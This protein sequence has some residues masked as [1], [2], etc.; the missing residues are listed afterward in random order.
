MQN[1]TPEG[2]QAIRDLSNRYR[3]S[4]EAVKSMFQ[5]VINGGGTMAQFNHPE[6]GGG[7]QWMQGGMTMIGDMFNQSLKFTVEG[8]CCELSNLLSN[9]SMQYTSNQSQSQNGGSQQQQGYGNVTG[10]MSVN[11][12]VSLFVQNSSQNWWPDVLGQANS[13]GGQNNV[14]YAYF[15]NKRRVA[16]EINNQVTVYDTLDH[17]IGGFSQQQGV[18]GSITL[19][20]Q[21][22]TV[23]IAELPI[24]TFDLDKTN[25]NQDVM[26]SEQVQ[27]DQ[28][29][30]PQPNNNYISN[31]K[32]LVNKTSEKMDIIATI[33]R[34][35]ELMGKGFITAEEFATKKTELLAKL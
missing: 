6:F 18:G 30:I 5:A 1:L 2:I 28:N 15:E 12:P 21:Y 26:K 3:V 20:S 27:V 32:T 9:Q 4:E 23:N 19:T 35:A 7:G 11:N 13:T 16:I 34:L 17:Q 10:N 24:V 14:R 29:F 22:G 33:E 31:E 25:K 8:L